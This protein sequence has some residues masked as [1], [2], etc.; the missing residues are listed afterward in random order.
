MADQELRARRELTWLCGR[1]LDW[2]T[3]V[4]EATA[5]IKR[6][7]PNERFC[8]HTVDPATLLLT[9]GAAR[10]LDRADGYQLIVRNE[11]EQ[12]DVNKWAVLARSQR[13]VGSLTTATSGRRE[14]SPRYIDLM[15]PMQLAWELRASL[16]SGG[17]CWGTAGIY[18]S[19]GERDFAPEEADFLARISPVLGEGFRRALVA[20]ALPL[21]DDLP[22][23]PGL[24]LFDEEA[25]VLEIAPAAE[26]WLD[27]LRGREPHSEGWLPAQV[28]AAA[29]SARHGGDVPATARVRTRAGRWLSLQG[30]RLSD[31]GRTAVIIQ[32]A[33]APEVAP[34]ILDSYGLTTRERAICELGLKGRSTNEIAQSLHVSPYT[35]QDHLKVI[36]EKVGVRSR[37]ELVARVFYEHYLPAS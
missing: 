36:F 16:V 26:R 22:D 5:V 31:A 17:Q 32:P 13:V 20:E 12:E 28:Y 34:L 14:R 35:V 15:R 37:R 3:L 18:R 1:G 11:Y 8:F 6:V 27:E 33:R 29:A 25:Q 24:I 30:V 10:N 21:C 2:Q 7:I 9:G 19:D 4:D 23:A